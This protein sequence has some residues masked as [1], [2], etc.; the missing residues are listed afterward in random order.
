[1][2]RERVGRQLLGRI[3]FAVFFTFSVWVNCLQSSES[4]CLSLCE[5]GIWFYVVLVADTF[6]PQ[7]RQVR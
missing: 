2:L 3:A 4:F 5:E 6:V 7:Y 1:M